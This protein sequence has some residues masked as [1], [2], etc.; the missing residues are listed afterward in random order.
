MSSYWKYRLGK[1]SILPYPQGDISLPA[2]ESLVLRFSTAYPSTLYSDFARTT[3]AGDGDFLRS[4]TQVGGGATDDVLDDNDGFYTPPTLVDDGTRLVVRA[5]NSDRIY[6]NTHD[7]SGGAL[8]QPPPNGVDVPWTA[9]IAVA[10]GNTDWIHWGNRIG[11]NSVVVTANGGSHQVR[12]GSS[13]NIQF[14]A[15]TT[16]FIGIYWYDGTTGYCQ[17]NNTGTIYSQTASVTIDGGAENGL[18]VFYR[19]FSAVTGDMCSAGIYD[20]ELSA[21]ERTQLYTLVKAEHLFP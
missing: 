3:Q 21:E 2:P 5:S 4:W 8:A 15:P 6:Q 20:T 19:G 16:P 13:I 14:T 9:W 1:G 18:G 7:D 17:I 12:M 10:S 11:N